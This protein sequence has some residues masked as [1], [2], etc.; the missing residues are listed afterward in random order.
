VAAAHTPASHY[1]SAIDSISLL[2]VV[3]PPLAAPYP[4]A[5]VQKLSIAILETLLLREA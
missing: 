4:S 2:H 3:S 1:V 5:E